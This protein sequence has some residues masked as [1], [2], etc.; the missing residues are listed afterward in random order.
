MNTAI[1][2]GMAKEKTRCLGETPVILK[3]AHLGFG[4]TIGLQTQHY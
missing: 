3:Q 4:F 1:V 2:V